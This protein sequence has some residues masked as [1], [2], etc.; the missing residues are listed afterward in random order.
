MLVHL[1]LVRLIISE[2]IQSSEEI[3]KGIILINEVIQYS[4]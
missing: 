1:Q 2:K 3:M 4:L